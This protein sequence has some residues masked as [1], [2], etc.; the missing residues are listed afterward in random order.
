MKVGIERFNLNGILLLLQ[1]SKGS[2]RERDFKWIFIPQSL[3]A[4]S[5]ERE[6]NLRDGW[7]EEFSS[8]IWREEEEKIL[9]KEIQ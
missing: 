4:S 2:E 5:L 3:S 7:E 9:R 8:R 6:E 1:L